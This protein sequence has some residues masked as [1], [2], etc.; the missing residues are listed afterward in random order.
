MALER[1]TWCEISKEALSSNIKK[2]QGFIGPKVTIMAVVK[3]N[4]YGHGSVETAKIVLDSGAEIL[5][6][7]SLV[8]AKQLRGAGIKAPVVILGFTPAQNY[9]DMVRHDITVTIRSLDVA[10]ALSTACIV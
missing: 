1:L 7:S 8:E 3:A 2:I 9:L 6:V 5:G 10:K 4:A